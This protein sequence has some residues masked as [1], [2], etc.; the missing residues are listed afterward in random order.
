MRTRYRR[1][2]SARTDRARPVLVQRSRANPTKGNPGYSC[3]AGAVDRPPAV[4]RQRTGGDVLVVSGFV[5]SGTLTRTVTACRLGERERFET[6]GVQTPQGEAECAHGDQD[7]WK[8]DNS[9]H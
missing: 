2:G 6:D 7:Q 3:S 4:S 9:T 5:V 1:T 8:R